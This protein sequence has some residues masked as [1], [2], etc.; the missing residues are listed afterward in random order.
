MVPDTARLSKIYSQIGSCGQQDDI[1]TAG[2]GRVVVIADS[3]TLDGNGTKISADG[4]P[5]AD[6]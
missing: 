5:Y 6:F 4:R 2:G 3:L 1:E